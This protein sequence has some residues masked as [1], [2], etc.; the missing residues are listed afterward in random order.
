[1]AAR[2]R[3][4]A[5]RGVW[6]LSDFTARHDL[7]ICLDT[8]FVVRALHPMEEHH[9][10]CVA[11]LTRIIDCESTL[12]FNELLTFELIETAYKL[13]VIERHGRQAWPA[14]RQDGR[15][16]R[17]ATRLSKDLLEAWSSVQSVSSHLEIPLADV[18]ENVI[19]LL[20]VGLSSYDA[21]HAATAALSEAHALATTDYGFS[22]ITQSELTIVTTHDRVSGYRRN[23]ARLSRG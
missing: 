20:S 10:E 5:H 7:R 1:M 23:R 22:R 8:S 16:R 15:V 2:G 19:P 11:F 18:R 21:A 6:A 12:V 3:P 14:K 9:D 4:A 17:R 13:A